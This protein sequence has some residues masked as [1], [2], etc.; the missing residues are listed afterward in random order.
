[1]VDN[2]VVTMRRLGLGVLAALVLAALGLNVVAYRHA[3]A[4]TRLSARGE[5]T[6]R[7]EALSVRQKLRVLATGATLPRPTNERT[8]AD[9][10]L[11]FVSQRF[12]TADGL[13]LEA[14]FVPRS[15]AR[16]TILL[17][18]GYADRKASLLD[19]ALAFQELGYASLLVDF[20]GSGGSQGD[21]TSIGYHEA[22]DVRA[23]LA[24]AR[25][26]NHARPF[27]LFG[28]SMGAAAV[29]RAVAQLHVVPDV[30][31]LQYP[32]S[33][34]SLTVARRFEAMGLPTF[35]AAPVLVFWGGWQ[36][37]FNGFR[38][39]PLD[40]ARAVRIP[41]LLMQGDRDDRVSMAEARAIY[42]K[43]AG[44]KRLEIFS[45]VGHQSLV[46]AQ[47]AQWRRA[48]AEFVEPRTPRR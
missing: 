11:E 47:P 1:M 40:Y 42:E 44:R 24:H 25:N 5:R 16:G 33:K 18:H 20:R 14:W 32:F 30:L 43:L 12:R 8:P 6:P 9:L 13:E 4:M 3:R 28:A 29:L 41:T 21:A 10:A 22:E 36:Q 2:R 34:M 15:E 19:A 31:V 45:G 7:P 48:V 27:V 38:H 35:P 17:F 39:N 23:A 46:Q 37:G 26:R